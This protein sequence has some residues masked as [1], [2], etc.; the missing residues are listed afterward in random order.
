MLL[1]LC[2]LIN[3]LIGVIFKYFGKWEV[4]VLIA[5]IVN[6]FTCVITGSMVYGKFVIG[7]EI[8]QAPWL[9]YAIFLGFVFVTIFNLVALTVRSYGIMIATIFQKM[10]LLFP[11]VVGILVYHETNSIL[12]T[13]GIAMAAA[14]IVMM[15]Y[16]QKTE[17]FTWKMLWLPL[18]TWIGSGVIEVTLLYVEVERLA[19]SADIRFVSSIFFFAGCFGLIFFIFSSLKAKAILVR[20]KDVFAGILLGIP[21]FFSIYLILVLLDRGWQGSALFP[22]NNVGILFCASLIGVALFS[23][24]I[25]TIKSIGFIASIASIIMVASG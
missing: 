4:N 1:A 13:A 23:E 11:A 15:A 18:G 21:N 25:D 2:I 9:P 16:P 8:L 14:S 22:I 19:V 5:I 3:T 20:K 10:S 6:Y 24:R 12:K 17:R 7:P